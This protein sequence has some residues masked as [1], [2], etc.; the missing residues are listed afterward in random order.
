MPSFFINRP[1]FAWV[2]A[3]LI[4]L[5]GVISMRS[6]G[7]DSYPDIAPPQ[8]TVTATYPGASAATM[9]S[10]VTQVIEQQ[11][12]GID[13][14]LYF[15]S[16]SSSNGQTVITLTFATGTNPDIAQVQVQNKVTLA[17]PLL[18]TP[19]IQQGVVVAK[20][21]PD[22]LMFLALQSSNPSIDAAR[23]SDILASQ[24][25]PAIGRVTG[26]GNTTLLGSEYAMRIWLDPDKLQSYGLS[27]TQVLDAVTSQNAQ[28]AAG[29]LGAD[30]AVKGQGFTATI[31]GDALL[32]SL[33]QFKGIV[34][35]ANN[36]GTV[37]R[38][39]DVAR[40]TFG[41][42][43]YGQAPVFNGKPA[44]G[45]AIFLLPGANPLSVGDAVKSEMGSLA[46]DLPAGVTRGAP[47]AMT[48]FIPPS[49]PHL[50]ET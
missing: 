25:Q 35:L 14:L 44:G 17:Q 30:P 21:S 27:T 15:S 43:T 10:T 42:Q 26:V 50:R 4:S 29:S 32:S 38:L 49:S 9:E 2:V 6:M 24:I 3:I 28:F 37:V 41:A 40:I 5:F 16:K 33:K 23:L 31:S 1:V 7:I 46:R 39:G 45:L 12:T 36:N 8:V 18:P 48:P 34:L 11:L 19:V 20:A 13:N 47:H 22:I